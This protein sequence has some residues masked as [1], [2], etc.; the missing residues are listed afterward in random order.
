MDSVPLTI[1]AE[2]AIETLRRIVTAMPR[3]RIITADG[4]YLHAEFTSALFRFVDDVEFFVDRDQR[5]IH[6]R[7][8]SRVGHSDLG[9]NRQRMQAIVAAW[10][11]ETERH[12]DEPKTER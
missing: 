9:V 8:A 7:S 6:F 5:V 4:D 1:D 11:R 10:R 3:T 2:H 12:L